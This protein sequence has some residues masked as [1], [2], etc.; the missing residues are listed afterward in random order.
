MARS[1]D[2]TSVRGVSVG[3]AETPE[4]LSGVTVVR[5]ETAAP[6]VVD[7]RGGASATY[8]TASLALEATFGRRWAIFFAGGSLFGLDAARGVRTRVLETGGG[9]SAFRNPNRVAPISGAALFDLPTT[10]GPLP[11]YTVL[12]YEAAR[13]AGRG[14]VAQGRV[15]A[16]AGA[17]VGKYLGREHAMHGGIGS[18]ARRI[19]GGGT[20]GAIVAV[21]AVGA[22][23]DPATSAWVAGARTPGG[24]IAP[25]ALGRP[26]GEAHRGTTLTLVATDLVVDRP[27]LARVASIVHAGLGRAIVPYQTSSDGD[28]VFAASTEL[29]PHRAVESW[30]GAFGDRVGWLAAESAVEATLAAVRRAIPALSGFRPPEGDAPQAADQVGLR[31]DPAQL[32]AVHDQDRRIAA[33]HRRQK[34]RGERFVHDRVGRLESVRDARTSCLGLGE[35]PQHGRLGNGADDP[36]RLD[37][38]KLENPPA[39]IRWAAVARGAVGS[40]VTRARFITSPTVNRGVASPSRCW[41]YPSIFSTSSYDGRI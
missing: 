16:G 41:R 23:R 29:V 18:A 20:V 27:T 6:T 9:R 3:H 7:V 40:T 33:Q 13:T 5:F 38:R 32:A 30:A 4:V 24:R 17:L 34:V 37:D 8:D 36:A 25:P 1:L 21:N 14:P 10:E 2:L 19:P 35:R 28:L 11:E 12:G 31:H 26:A 15:G 22:V 39:S